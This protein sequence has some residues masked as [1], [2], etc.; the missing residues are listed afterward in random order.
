MTIREVIDTVN[1]LKPN[2]IS[3]AMK[4]AWL[5]DLDQKAFDEVILTHEW[6]GEGEPE[7]TPYTG[8]TD[9]DT[10]LL[11]TGANAR[12]IYIYYLE[13]M[14]DRENAEIAKYNATSSFFNVAYNAWSGAY[15]R[16]NRPKKQGVFRF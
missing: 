16:N 9:E 3:D 13:A 15:N 10:E 2:K 4:V 8:D 14:I 5:A 12:D 6:P 7:Y 1:V 11:I